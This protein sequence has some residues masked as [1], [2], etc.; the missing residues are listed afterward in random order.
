MNLSKHVTLAEFEASGTA[1]NHSI[2]NKMNEFEIQR[3]K[4]L[5]EKV[6]EPLRSYI[7]E[8][9]RINSGFRSIATNRACGGAKNSQHC[10]A[11]AMDLHIGAK[12]FNYIKD[13]LVFDQL[14]WEFGTDKEPA[15]VHV[16]Y[17]KIGNR[18][19]VLKA[20]KK[21]GKTIYTPY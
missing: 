17:K 4:L 16:S 19:Q 20:T 12:G 1:T 11:E 21:N 10:L 8:P 9:I 6:F 13:H 15:W 7:G 3:A 14:I 5:C 2:L 18:K